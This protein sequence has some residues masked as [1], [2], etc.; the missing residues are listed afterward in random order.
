MSHIQWL[1]QESKYIKA[2]ENIGE[3]LS[4]ILESRKIN[5]YMVKF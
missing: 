4:V 3:Y 1:E 2:R 5:T